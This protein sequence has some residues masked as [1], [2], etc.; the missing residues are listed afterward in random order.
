MSDV[1]IKICGVTTPE[2]ARIAADLGADYLGM[3][4]SQGFKRSILPGRAV[5]IELVVDAP[6]V[7]VFVDESV[8]EV[9]RI[10]GM[11]G[12]SVIQ[13]AGEEDLGYVEELRRRGDWAIW[14]VIRVRDPVTAIHT[15]REWGPSVDGVLL[16]GWHESYPGGGGVSF[17]WDEMRSVRVEIPEGVDLIA[18]G[19]L[20]PANVASAADTLRPD[21]VDVS[22][23]VELQVGR[24]DPDLIR[25]FIR[26][27][28]AGEGSAPV[29][30]RVE[31]VQ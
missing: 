24:K 26:N 14:K 5:D 8:S 28:R 7:G 3:I 11:V 4:L 30:D 23:G 17:S 31:D 16:D 12:T 18:A 19:G 2:D 10:C 22:S 20:R 25:S 15:V 9:E 29:E 1:R 6:L 21:V 13:L 27:A